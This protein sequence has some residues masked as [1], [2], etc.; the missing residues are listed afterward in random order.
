VYLYPEQITVPAGK[1]TTVALHFRI[2]PVAA[3]QLAHAQRV[4]NSFQ[5]FIDSDGSGAAGRA[6]IPG[7][8]VT[9]PADPSMKLSVY[10]GEFVVQRASM[11]NGRASGRGKVALPGLRP[12]CLHAPR[13]ITARLCIGK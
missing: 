4:T 7:S 10:T 3:H 13:T 8:S 1:T 11:Y 12:Q 6:A 9:L 5:R 2:A